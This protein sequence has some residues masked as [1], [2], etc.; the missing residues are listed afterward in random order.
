[1]RW[2]VAVAALAFAACETTTEIRYVKCTTIEI[3]PNDS[4]PTI[5]DS[6]RFTNCNEPS[7]E[8][9]V[10]RRRATP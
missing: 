8:G 6:V 5:A 9:T 3:F 7:W 10:I 4:T 1:M 2:W